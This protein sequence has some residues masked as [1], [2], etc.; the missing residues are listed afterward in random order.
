MKPHVTL[1][2]LVEIVSE[3]AQ[4][5]SELIATVIHMIKSGQVELRSEPQP[6]PF[7]MEPVHAFA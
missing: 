1:I 4:S 3:F 2:D 6:M 5:E 7:A